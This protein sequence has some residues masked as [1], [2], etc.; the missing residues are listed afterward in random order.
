MELNLSWNSVAKFAKLGNISALEN[1]LVK[2][3]H[4]FAHLFIYF[5]FEKTSSVLYNQH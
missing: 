5:A 3:S 4:D 2:N 1:N